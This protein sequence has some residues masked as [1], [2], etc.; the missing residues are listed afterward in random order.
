ME[1]QGIHDNQA[2]TCIIQAT[3]SEQQ[4]S[5]SN[6]LLYAGYEEAVFYTNQKEIFLGTGWNFQKKSSYFTSFPKSMTS[7]PEQPDLHWNPLNSRL[8][9]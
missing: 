8:K 5:S 4:F 9:I 6:A 3:G 1:F 2:S 7:F